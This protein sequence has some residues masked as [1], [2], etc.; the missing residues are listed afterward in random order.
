MTL[1]DLIRDLTELKSYGYA[2]GKEK[3]FLVTDPDAPLDE[4]LK[5][6]GTIYVEEFPFGNVFVQINSGD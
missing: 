6:V 2:T 3:V 1:D 4:M 5:P